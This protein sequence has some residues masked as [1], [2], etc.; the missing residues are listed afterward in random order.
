MKTFLSIVDKNLFQNCPVKRE[1]IVAAERI[2]GPEVGSLMGKTVRRTPKTVQATYTNIPATIIS[3]YKE[4]TLAGDIMFVNKL[5]FFVT[6]S[7]NIQ[8]YTSQFLPKWKSD[9]I[10]KAITH[11]HQMY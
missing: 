9:T 4:V 2:F 1:D 10:F 8:F 5:P 6:I 11:V 7:R 3:R